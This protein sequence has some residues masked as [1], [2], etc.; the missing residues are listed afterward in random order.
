M[1]EYSK[2]IGKDLDGFQSDFDYAKLV[3]RN[4]TNWQKFSAIA[5]D[6]ILI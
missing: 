4:D 6:S 3:T 5:I 2:G 1:F